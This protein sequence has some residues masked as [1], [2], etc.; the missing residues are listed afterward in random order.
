LL[1]RL[2]KISG[3]TEKDNYMKTRSQFSNFGS[4]LLLALLWGSSAFASTLLVDEDKVECPDAGYNSI[5]SAV[6]AAASGDIIQVCPGTYDEQVEI[7][8][9]LTL[10]GVKRDDKKA[11][12]L[13]P[14]NMQVNTDL[15]GYPTAAAILVRDTDDVKIRNITV[16]GINNG[17]V[18]DANTPYIDGIYYRNASGEVAFVAIRNM[19]SPDSCAYGDGL[20]VQGTEGESQLTVRDSSIHD[21]DAGGILGIGTGLSLSA[22][23]NVVTGRGPVPDIGQAGIQLIEG[24]TGSIE[25]NIVSNNLT[26]GCPECDFLSTSILVFSTEDVRVV[27]NTLS[28]SNMGMFI[29]GFN[30]FDS[31]RATVLDNRVS[32]SEPFDGMIVIGEDNIVKNNNITHSEYLGMYVEGANNTI[33]N[34]TINEAAI[35]LLVSSGNN[36]LH[37]CLFNTPVTKE[38]FVAAAPVP[39][40]QA[41]PRQ[42]LITRPVLRNMHR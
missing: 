30:G 40:R 27:R 13:Q 41:S 31:N 37:N 22:I 24:A 5:Q 25:E 6:D 34:N 7:A 4:A 12:V 14:S 1:Q 42:T 29:G 38:M 10:M 36:V 35:G 11:V 32:A 15:L 33:Q 8:K 28:N 17:I 26:A 21:Y 16:D 20:D 2:R 3:E 18:C 9:P 23:R 39:E 19:V